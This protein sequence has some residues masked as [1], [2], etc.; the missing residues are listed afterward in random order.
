MGV[1]LDACA[2]IAFIRSE[3]GADRVEQR[4]IE[5][6]CLVHA[7]NLCEVYYDCIRRDGE[8]RAN[9]ILTDLQDAGL[10]AR[11]DIDEDFWKDAGRIKAEVARI[12]LADC[13]AVALARRVGMPV[14][15]SDHHE[16]DNILERG[17]CAVQF[18]R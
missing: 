3:D 11:S 6:G 5:G 8:A 2:L 9:A 15:T 4:L 10:S 18:L 13:F 17:L 14:M 12:S 7:L 1:V 16:F